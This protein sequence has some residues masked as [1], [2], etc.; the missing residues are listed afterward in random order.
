MEYWTLVNILHVFIIAPLLIVIG[1]A[2]TRTPDWLFTVLLV[3]AFG[4][5][6]YH[7]YRYMETKSI[8]NIFHLVAIVP[9]LVFVALEKKQTP[10]YA[11]LLLFALG[12]V[13][14]WYHGK[15]LA[16]R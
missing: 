3:V 14:L 1:L 2:Q 8:V 4:M 7:I 13:S 6:V 16:S 10:T 9:L 12:I 11:F 5:T 15:K